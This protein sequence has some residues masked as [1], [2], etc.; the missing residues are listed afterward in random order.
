MIQIMRFNDYQN[1]NEKF[2]NTNFICTLCLIHFKKIS[3]FQVA[4]LRNSSNVSSA[5]HGRTKQK[6]SRSKVKFEVMK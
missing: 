6:M 4:Y 1:P 3:R 2:I 5:V